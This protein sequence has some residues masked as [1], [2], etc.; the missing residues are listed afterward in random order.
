MSFML[1]TWARQSEKSCI[2]KVG[3]D[4]FALP[5]PFYALFAGIARAIILLKI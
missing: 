4:R 5:L 1:L 3:L 2:G